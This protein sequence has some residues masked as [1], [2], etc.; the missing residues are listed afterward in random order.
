MQKF[1][2]NLIKADLCLC[3]G[4]FMLGMY[5]KVSDTH[6]MVKKLVKNKK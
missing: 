1:L 4:L 3:V 5:A 2:T 6:N